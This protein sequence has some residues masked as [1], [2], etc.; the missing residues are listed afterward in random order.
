MHTKTPTPYLL[1]SIFIIVYIALG[2]LFEQGTIAYLLLGI[3]LTLLFQGVVVKQPLHKLWM[4]DKDSFHLNTFG[5]VITACFL[6]FPVYQL[7]QSVSHNTLTLVNLG[8][9]TAIMLGAFGAGYCYSNFTKKTVS[10][11]LLCFVITAALRMSLYFF[12][13]LFGKDEFH[14]DYIRAI[15]SLLTYIPVVFVVEEV[16]FRGMLDSYV[17]TSKEGNGLVSAFFVSVLW[18]LWHLPLAYNGEKAI[19][20][21]ALGSILIA[22]WGI[23]LSIFMRRS[24]NLAVPGFS[25]A[26]A[27][28]IRDGLK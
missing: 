8:F 7:I 17:H 23:V 28:A 4:R 12:P 16:V 26:L 11:F 13:F 14:P 27:D 21:V 9:Y 24:G 6:V 19:W 25:H 22:L 10:Y 18:G 15:K 20:L 5:W 1:S 3:P 2:F